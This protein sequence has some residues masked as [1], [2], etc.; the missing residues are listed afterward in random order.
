MVGGIFIHVGNLAKQYSWAF[1][2]LPVAE[3]IAASIT[4]VIGS[5]LNYFLDNRINNAQILFPGVGCFLIAVFLGTAVHFSNSADNKAKLHQISE[6]YK[7]GAGTVKEFKEPA[8]NNG[9]MENGNVD[10]NKPKAGSADFLIELENKRS[11]KVGGSTTLN[12]VAYH[13]ILQFGS[14]DINHLFAYASVV[15][16]T[17]ICSPFDISETLL[18]LIIF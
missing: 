7:D 4:V 15:T 2:G 17:S 10:V 5:T 14:T 13:I 9:D 3:V 11:I 18:I 16:H 1:V 6:G 8:L 12:I